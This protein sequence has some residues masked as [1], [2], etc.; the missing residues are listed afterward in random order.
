MGNNASSEGGRVSRPF[1]RGSLGLSKSE[2]DERCRPSG[3]YQ[4]CQ[5]D[6]RAIRRLVAD[7]RLAARL[8]GTDGRECSTDHE[9]PICFLH[10]HQVNV[11]QCCQAD[12][13]TECYLQVRPQKEKSPTCPFCNSPRLTIQVAKTMDAAAVQE[14]QSNE[15]QVLE[16]KMRA[17]DEDNCTGF[18][19]SM[20][21]NTAVRLMRARSE[22]MSSSTGGETDVA[23]VAMT[24]EDRH[25]L[26]EEIRA[27]HTHPL[28]RRV[29]QEAEERRIENERNFYR[30]SRGLR[31]ARMAA[32]DSRLLGNRRASNSRNW[33]EI[34]NAFESHG[35]GEVN[36]LD[37][38]VVLEAAI[39][40]SMAEEDRRREGGTTSS[41]NN[42]ETD[43]TNFNAVEHARQG[44]PLVQSMLTDSNRPSALARRPSA[45]RRAR[46]LR[47]LQH[48][49]A[50]DLSNILLRGISEAE[51][52]EM[53]IA[54][55]LQ[56]SQQSEQPDN[57]NDEQAQQE[58]QQETPGQ[59]DAASESGQSLQ[60]EDT[61]AEQGDE[62]APESNS[63]G[64][65]NDEDDNF[66][67]TQGSSNG[68][69]TNNE[70]VASIKRTDDEDL[71]EM[72][73]AVN[74]VARKK[75]RS[76]DDHIEQIDNV[77]GKASE[78]SE[79]VDLSSRKPAALETN[80]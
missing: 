8:K 65:H 73:T 51:Q 39:M 56:Q 59:G 5:W 46:S 27:Q 38:L 10:Y 43:E 3:L 44:F 23:S 4:S 28:A 41:D 14:R 13:C 77:V 11:T 33:N 50:G 16:A 75:R 45:S 32:S 72:A 76:E 74:T 69:T 6:D 52:I 15:Q 61:V 7:G 67:P 29:E 53:A 19:S 80:D 25:V 21:Q 62:R 1:A 37:D 31:I 70:T 54:M 34:V 64:T 79:S 18:G 22:S 36:S 55:S 49:D 40:L 12:I 71:D 57:S 60:V 63:S 68:S 20:E 58:N 9:C 35:N 47:H 26:E 24:P 42:D 66:S 2:V 78:H 48:R 17:R 30:S